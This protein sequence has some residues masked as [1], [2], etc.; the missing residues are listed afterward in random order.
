MSVSILNNCF[1]LVKVSYLKTEYSQGKVIFWV[2]LRERRCANCQSFNVIQKGKLNRVLHTVPVGSKL[3][4]INLEIRRFLCLDCGICAQESFNHIASPKKHYTKRLASFVCSLYSHMTVKDIAQYLHLHWNTVWE[5]L[6]KDLKKSI[7]KGRELRKLRI[8]GIDEISIRKGHSY[9]TLVIDHDTGRVVHVAA[10][11]NIQSI[12]SFLKR[13]RKLKAPVEVITTDMWI[14]YISAIMDIL[15]KS[16]I[17][18]DKF[19]II[20]LLNRSIDELRREEYWLYSKTER[21]IIKGTRFLLFK[22]AA[23]LTEPAKEKLKRLLL[24]NKN[25]AVCYEMK[26]MLYQ[27]WEC[28]TKEEAR[29][30]LEQWSKMAYTSTIQPLIKFANQLLA[31]KTAVLNYFEYPY[32]NALIE[33]I[34]NKMKVFKRQVY[35]FRNLKNFYLKIYSIHKSRYAL[36]G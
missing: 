35:G 13:L 5:I 20:A 16:H 6:S 19:H 29:S 24:V 11:R 9:L 10:G 30:F 21:D 8:I 22:H 2:R 32:T 34:N 1:G 33:G 25:L 7:P 31:F 12:R 26:E 23:N 4:S 17:V 28:S 27:F 18:F 14:P 15:P 36:I 3:V